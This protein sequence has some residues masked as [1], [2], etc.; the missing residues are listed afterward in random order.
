MLS[1]LTHSRC[2]QCISV[3]QTDND[4]ADVLSENNRAHKPAE[5]L[6]GR[7]PG[8]E[9]DLNIKTKVTRKRGGKK[10]HLEL[11]KDVRKQTLVCSC[12]QRF[13]GVSES[14]LFYAWGKWRPNRGHHDESLVRNRWQSVRQLLVYTYSKVFFIKFNL[15]LQY[16]HLTWG[17]WGQLAPVASWLSHFNISRI[18]HLF[19]GEASWSVT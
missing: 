12:V 2:I 15:G 14:A 11:E 3:T 7:Q 16:S 8:E 5:Q 19:T 17:C 10:S 4:T 13:Q 6:S 9:K 1:T 18:S